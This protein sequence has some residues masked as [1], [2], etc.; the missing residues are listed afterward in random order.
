MGSGP[1]GKQL[2]RGRWVQAV[3]AGTAGAGEL[4][5]R[6]VSSCSENGIHVST[7]ESCTAGLVAASIADVAGASNVLLG[8]AVT[9]TDAIK[10]RVLH[11]SEETLEHC[12]AVS[13]RC[14]EELAEGSRALFGSDA[15]VSV[16]GYAGP[17]GGTEQDPVGTVCFGLA[18]GSGV[19][20]CRVRFD[21]S[22]AEVRSQAAAFALAL[23]LD[24]VE[25]RG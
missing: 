17:G 8:G 14:A 3:L 5:E 10:H 21:G 20:S 2:A 7:A 4:S 19:S 18:E 22:R 25:M 16:T 12:T 23:L 15:A 13:E 11:V 24:A 6:L 1:S 9:Y